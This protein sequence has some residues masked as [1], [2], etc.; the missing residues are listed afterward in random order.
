[1]FKTSTEIVL[2]TFHDLKVNANG[3]S[4]PNLVTL[5]LSYRNPLQAK[6]KLGIALEGTT[7]KSDP[8]RFENNIKNV[9]VW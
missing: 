6:F 7:F 5:I 3:F 1:M 8:I 9:D 4:L 2:Q